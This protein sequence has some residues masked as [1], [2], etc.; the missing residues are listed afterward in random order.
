MNMKKLGLFTL[1][2]FFLFLG[3]NDFFIGQTSGFASGDMSLATITFGTSPIE[4]SLIIAFKV[5]AGGLFIVK[6]LSKA[7]FDKEE[8]TVK[9]LDRFQAYADAFEES[10]ADDNWQRLEEYFSTD[11]VYAPGDG[12]EAVG[13]DQVIVQLRDGVDGLD[14]RFDSRSLTAA[15]PNSEGHTVSLSW[16]LKLSKSGAP[17]L[18]VTGIEQATYKGGVISHLEDVF[19]EGTV[20]ELGKWMSEHGDSLSS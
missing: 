3:I 5:I 8:D 11:A 13:R 12:T 18:I 2:L 17:D 1:G 14:R 7:E 20:E 9:N 16:Q 6:G 4:F 19:D 15:P 10:Y